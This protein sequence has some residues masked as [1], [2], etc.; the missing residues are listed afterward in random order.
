MW[1]MLWPV[2]IVVA[3]N[4]IYNISA[5]STPVNI[6]SFA[7]L[8]VTYLTAMISSLIMYLTTSENKN[9]LQELSKANWTTYALGFAILGLEVGYLYI[10]RAGWKISI[11]NLFTSISLT[12]VL[13]I[14]GFLLYREVLSFRQILGM[15]ICVIGLILIV[16]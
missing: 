15:G 2:L 10:Y 14:V 11:A 13:L 3:S 4:T 12:C 8:S 7:S 1:N 9:L 6:N 16:K 5:K